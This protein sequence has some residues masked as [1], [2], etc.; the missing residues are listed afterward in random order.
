MTPSLYQATPAT[1]AFF[2]PVLIDKMYL[3][4]VPH[5]TS[6]LSVKPHPNGPTTQQRGVGRVHEGL[7]SLHRRNSLGS[8][9]VRGILPWDM[10]VLKWFLIY[11]HLVTL[12]GAPHDLRLTKDSQTTIVGCKR[13][14]TH[15]HSSYTLAKGHTALHHTC[16]CTCHSCLSSGH[17]S[18]TSA[19][20]RGVTLWHGHL[21]RSY[22]W[23]GGGGW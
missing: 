17:H 21:P 9:R 11:K 6:H 13:P 23:S 14:S 18:I 15:V 4:A 22:T 8:T 7:L 20:S 1:R 5:Y 3:K 12:I 10:F 19:S 16:L 2:S